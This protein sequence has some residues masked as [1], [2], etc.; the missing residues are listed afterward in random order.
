MNR[1]IR[2]F[3]LIELMVTVAIVGLLAAISVPM[4]ND[5]ITTSKQGVLTENINSIR[6]FQEDHKL[7]EGAYAAG[8]YPFRTGQP[9]LGAILGWEPRTAL[10]EVT[11]VVD[12]VTASGF[13]VTA[14]HDDGTTV[15]MS[16]P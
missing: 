7:Y 4:Y 15:V 6:L 13:R 9:D 3:S 10:D 12:N 5:Y 11:Y 8:E 16:F 14:T 1:Q 2:G